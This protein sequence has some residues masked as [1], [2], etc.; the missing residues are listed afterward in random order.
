[1]N[2]SNKACFESPWANGYIWEKDDPSTWV[3]L[4]SVYILH[5]KKVDPLAQA[6]A[7]LAHASARLD[8]IDAAVRWAKLSV[9][10][11]RKVSPVRKITL[12]LQNSDLLLAEAT[13]YV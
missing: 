10:M 5:K 1:M 13:I 3:T 9:Y 8:W 12:P 6:N 7:A 11:W 2:K 4:A